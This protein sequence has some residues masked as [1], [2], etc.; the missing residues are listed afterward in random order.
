MTTEWAAAGKPTSDGEML[1]RRGVAGRGDRLVLGDEVEDLPDLGEEIALVIEE[2]DARS[3]DSEHGGDPV[4][5]V[6]LAR[7]GRE[8][9]DGSP[10]PQGCLDSSGVEPADAEVTATDP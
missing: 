2:A 6:L 7:D 8:P 5:H 9:H 10:V 1:G 3:R 4:F